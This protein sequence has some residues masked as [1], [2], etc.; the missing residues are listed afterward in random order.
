MPDSEDLETPIPVTQ[1]ESE[2]DASSRVFGPTVDETVIHGE[3][4]DDK[5]AAAAN[6]YLVLVQR[7][8][9]L[10]GVSFADFLETPLAE[11]E[12]EF[13]RLGMNLPD[14]IKF[15]NIYK[16][17]RSDGALFEQDDSNTK[18]KQKKKDKKDKKVK[19]DKKDKKKETKPG[20]KFEA[21]DFS[22]PVMNSARKF[23]IVGL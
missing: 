7:Y 2:P 9:D 10:T 17:N 22:V 6:D 8:P 19:K 1:N 13:K 4:Q 23:I 18:Q 20:V 5:G 3:N 15:R 12:D 11:W 14:K 16:E 21:I